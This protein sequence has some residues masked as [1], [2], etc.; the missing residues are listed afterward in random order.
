MAPGEYR[1]ARPAGSE[2][3]AVIRIEGNNLT[4]D[5]TGVTLRG[6]APTVDP[7]ARKGIAVE[8]KGDNVTIRGLKAHGYMHGL[9]VR[10]SD[11]FKLFDSDLSYNHKQ[12]LKSTNEKED[13]ADWMSYHNNEEDQWLRFGTGVYLDGCDGF[14]VKNLTVVG[15]QNGLMM[16]R[17]NNGL[18][19]NSNLS[20][21][22]SVGLGM[23]R[24]SNNR[25]MHNN[26]DWCVRG[27]SHGVYNRGQ[28]STGIL[29]YEQAH[30][31]TF[32]YNSVTH[33]GDGF[34][35]WAGQTTMDTGQGGC[36]DNVL[37]ANDFSHAPTNGIEATFSR[38]VFANNLLLE[39]WHGVWGG[40]SYDTKIVGN[41]FGLNAEGI[42]LEHGQ[43]NLLEGNIFRRETTAVKIWA[44][45]TQDPNWGYP[46]NRDTR[47]RDWTI[48]NNIFI[49]TV[50]AVFDLRRTTGVEIVDNFIKNN[51]R[52]FQIGEAVSGVTYARNTLWLAPDQDATAEGVVAQ[53][54]S[55][56]RG[57]GNVP[58]PATMQPS[59]NVIQG[60]DLD[61][62][63]YLRR[64]SAMEW[65]GMAPM[66]KS[67]KP[68]SEMTPEE[69][70]QTAAHP[71]MVAPLAGGKDPFL[72][73]G[74]LRGRRFILIDQWGPYDFKS[75]RMVL[76]SKD[77]GV[78]R[79]EL[80]GPAGRWTL[81]SAS[82][83]VTLGTQSGSVPG[84]VDV[85]LAKGGNFE[86]NLE[87]IGGETTDY[88]GVVTPAG[89]PVAFGFKEFKIPIEWDVKFWNYELEAHD[90]RTKTDAFAAVLRGTPAATLTTTELF[91]SWGGSPAQGVN[92]DYFA[93][94]ADGTFTIEPGEYVIEVTHDDG[95]RVSLDG[96]QV[97][98]DWTYHGPRNDE[99]KVT[100]GGSHRLKVEHFELNGYSTLQV[101]IR[102]A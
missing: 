16:T 89:R 46:K 10:D 26:I 78:M 83:G 50:Q 48:K 90:P 75:P 65:T 85:R 53:D 49:D 58:K 84:Y 61:N 44:N 23:Y 67:S 32:A 100:L 45:P 30:K 47:S 35:L 101:R 40:Y 41:V 59:G 7:D 57:A 21:L 55:V 73:E 6:T 3:Q 76:R 42:A 29:I 81:K 20:F 1:L 33:G 2:D 91:G 27:Y 28:D 5:F 38:N 9:I 102:K 24:S 72:K 62:A 51:G 64:F 80:L 52:I 93:T 4:V 12:R 95:V 37:Y 71:Y 98:E 92:P 77:G 22:S 63:A 97:F 25:L 18:V 60:L 70:R 68:A 96:K 74:T 19:W 88:R 34:F 69:L 56:E 14:E 8:V 15:G 94:V 87:Y 79:Y 17:S 31:N 54:N 99:I 36:N 82:E 86:V 13:T 66:V 11:G 39:C 43:D